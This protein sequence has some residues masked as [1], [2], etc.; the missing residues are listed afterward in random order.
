MLSIVVLGAR[1]TASEE[2][3]DDVSRPTSVRRE[4]TPIA[5]V[6]DDPTRLPDLL[7]TDARLRLP[8]S[9]RMHCAPVTVANGLLF[10]A[11]EGW[12]RLA[13]RAAE[14]ALAASDL[15][16]TLASSRYMNTS[17]AEGTSTAGILR[18]LAR[19]LADRGYATRRLDYAGWRAHPAEHA[20][21]AVRPDLDDLA[22]TLERPG[23]LAWF[24]VGWYRRT[25]DDG[26]WLRTGGH[27]VTVA[28]RRSTREGVVWILRD[29]S[30]RSGARARAEHA[31]LELLRGGS[32][33]GPFDGLPQTAHGIPRIV[34]GLER[35]PTCDAALV[36]G[37]VVLE[38]APRP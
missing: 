24:N 22:R 21:G 11:G 38:L 37:V 20:S 19:F 29:S 14:P 17:L 10:L 4:P 18:G 3:A 26:T 27:W 28:G 33:A 34:E 9:G 36:D 30:P 2:P 31:R 15:V 8:R 7:Q 6:A 5:R 13:P 25:S 16:A 12:E 32:V 1:P 23:A 35:P